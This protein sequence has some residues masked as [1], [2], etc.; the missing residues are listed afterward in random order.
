MAAALN[1]QRRAALANVGA[2]ATLRDMPR[3]RSQQAPHVLIADDQPDVLNALRLLLRNEGFVVTVASSPAGVRSAVGTASFDAVLID[4]NYTRDTTSG[5]EGLDLL[6]QLHAADPSLPVVV[7]TAWGSIE[8]AVEAMRCGARDFIEKPWDNHRLLA[9]VRN[10]VMLARESRH[11][12]RLEAENELLVLRGDD[13]FVAESPSMRGVLAM[14]ARVAPSNAAVLITGENGTG[15]SA[16]ARM[17]HR[18]SDRTAQAFVSVNMG[19]MPESV[20]ESEMFGHVKGAFTDAKSDRIGRF[21]LADG[22]TLFLDEIGNI[23]LAQQAKLLRVVENG[24]FERVGSSRTQH[25]DVRLISATN[26]DLP[27]LVAQQM[28]RQDLL[29]RLNTLE[30]RVPALRER[31][32]DIAALAAGRLATCQ[33]KYKREFTGL[34]PVASEALDNYAWPG[35]VRELNNIIERAVLMSAG[36]QIS[37]QDLRLTAAPSIAAAIED[38][39]L[40]DAERLLLTTALKRANGNVNAAADALG[41]SRSAM[42]RRIEKLGVR[43]ERL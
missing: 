15:K 11:G 28:F 40:D 24:E 4:L 23:P 39:S 9:V 36:P 2:T 27:S 43:I 19:A 16:L 34:D 31:R 3:S 7:M 18:A 1:T 22:G 25:C 38:M 13:E 32:A 8:L 41:L 33:R 26:A 12:A 29:F 35:N 20:F 17:L 37:V 10:Q 5:R 14:V 6:A 30:I 42:Y 21:E